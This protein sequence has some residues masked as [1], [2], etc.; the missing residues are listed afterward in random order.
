MI[1]ADSDFH[2]GPVDDDCASAWMDAAI[3]HA[4][5]RA[6]VGITQRPAGR[7]IHGEIERFPRSMT[8]PRVCQCVSRSGRK[9]RKER[10][11]QTLDVPALFWLSETYWKPT[12]SS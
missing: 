8:R 2:I 1:F 9:P 12:F 5:N 7:R 6:V 10:C 11:Q 4:P 3:A